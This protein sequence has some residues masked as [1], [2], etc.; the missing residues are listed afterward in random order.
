MIFQLPRPHRTE[1]A[2]RLTH[3]YIDAY[4][5]DPQAERKNN[6]IGDRPRLIKI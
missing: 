5:L 3:E 1:P 4:N 6:T 2:N